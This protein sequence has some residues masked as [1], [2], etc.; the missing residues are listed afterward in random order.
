MACAICAAMMLR[1]SPSV[2]AIKTSA[3]SIP[4]RFKS[5]GSV[6]SPTTA[7]PVKSAGKGAPG[8]SQIQLNL[9]AIDHSHLMA[10]VG[11]LTRKP[12]ADPAAADDDGLHRPRL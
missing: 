12:G 4:A 5:S 3:F 2:T 7:V 9:A 11:H 1:L 6:P 10:L 8:G